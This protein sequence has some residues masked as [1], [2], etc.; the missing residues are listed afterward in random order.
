MIRKS[1]CLSLM[2]VLILLVLSVSGCERGVDAP[3]AGS[4]SGRVVLTEDHAQGLTGVSLFILDGTGSYVE[5]DAGGY[6]E[7]TAPSGT[8]IIPRKVG[9]TFFPEKQVLEEGRELTFAAQAWPEPDFSQWGK[10]FAFDSH[11]DRV[12]TVAFSADDQYIAT[13]SS[14]RTIRIWRTSDGQLMGTIWGHTSVVKVISFSPQGDYLASATSNGEIK[15]WDWRTGWEIQ[16]MHADTI[17][18]T[19]LAWSPDGG[20]LASSSWDGEVKVW[21]AVTGDELRTLTHEKWVRA[22]AWSPDGRFLFTGGDELSLKAWEV[23]LGELSAE[24]PV[25]DKILSLSAAPQGSLV[26]MAL[27]GGASK[28]LNVETGEEIF[29]EQFKAGE[30]T[31]SWSADGR[32]LASGRDKLIQI[33]DM[34]TR[35]WCRV[36]MQGTMCWQW[37]GTV[38]RSAWSAGLT[39]ASSISG[40]QIQGKIC[41][42]SWA[43]TDM[44]RRWLGHL[45]ETTWPQVTKAGS[46]TSGISRRAGTCCSCP[47]ITAS[48][49][50]VWPGHQM[51]PTWPAAGMICWC[52]FGILPEA[53]I[54]VLSLSAS[55]SRLCTKRALSL[56]WG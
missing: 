1:K 42:E 20:K 10:Q 56:R 2:V 39:G 22:V 3:E 36:S 52:A 34:E 5:T 14:D 8:V 12:E 32:Y 33:W 46:S 7:T 37:I 54:L 25:R 38:Q 11:F 28:V 18:L 50:K 51:V 40:R 53:N 16:S 29:L 55:R 35:G 9:Y 44:S 48:L 21:D 13:G 26:A 19:D 30:T 43:T 4:I 47:A 31:F 17:L 27:G 15:I 41:G 45:R 6:F 49:W 23:E 24:I